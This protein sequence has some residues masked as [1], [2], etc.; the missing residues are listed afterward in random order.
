MTMTVKISGN[1]KHLS[2]ARRLDEG[3][4]VVTKRSRNPGDPRSTIPPEITMESAASSKAKQLTAWLVNVLVAVPVLVRV[5]VVVL[6]WLYLSQP[7]P[8]VNIYLYCEL[9]SVSVTN[10]HT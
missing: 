4:V 9:V 2:Y 8:C 5:L 1:E 6:A 10:V 7:P 3:V